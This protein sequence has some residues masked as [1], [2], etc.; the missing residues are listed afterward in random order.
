MKSIYIAGPMRNCPLFNFPA[1]D[2]AR[3]FLRSIGFNPIS[4]VDLD[5]EMGFDP[6]TDSWEGFSLQEAIK[7]DLDAIMKVA[8]SIC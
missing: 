8:P 4:P 3:D 7:R 2:K 1:F 5:R 6:A